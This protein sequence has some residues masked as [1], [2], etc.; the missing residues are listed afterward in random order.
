[1]LL[2]QHTERMTEGT[3]PLLGQENGLQENLRYR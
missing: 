3:T 2:N 1:M